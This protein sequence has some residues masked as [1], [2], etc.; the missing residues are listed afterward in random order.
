M[1]LHQIRYFLA[2][3]R[4]MNFT[5]AAEQCNVTQPA[6]TKAIQK[7]E[8][9]LGGALL[10]RERHLTQLTDLGKLVLPMLER[11]FAAAESVRNSAAE[12]RRRKIAPLKIALASGISAAIIE[13][14]LIELARFIPGL[15]VELCEAE[16]SEI[17]D[18]LF[19]GSVNAA[20][21]GDDVGDMP[22]RIDH[23][24]LFEESYLVLAPKA[25]NYAA[26]TVS[27]EA[28]AQAIWL[29]R[30]GCE[31]A[32]L[33]WRR[34]FPQ[35][36]VPKVGHRGRNIGHLQYMV[37]AGLGLMLWPEH[38]P[39]LN[40]LVARPIDGNPLKR[41]LQLRIVQGR[42]YSPAMEAFLKIA[43]LHDWSASLAHA[44]VSSRSTELGVTRSSQASELCRATEGRSQALATASRIS[45]GSI[46]AM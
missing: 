41:T 7:L 9:E 46:E 2:L 22:T 16:P 29:E 25:S 38:M 34:L 39:H 20:I 5:R 4:C 27:L 23:W 17:T 37:S 18:L 6:L 1:E 13:A 32:P 24:S 14:P 15:Q 21:T 44:D 40:T 28:M 31:A 8:Q 11:S 10:H 36:E 19:N 45:A 3:T 30:T 26:R 35:G 43:R 33:L 12:F 42:R